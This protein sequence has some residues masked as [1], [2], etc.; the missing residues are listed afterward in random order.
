VSNRR[1]LELVLLGAASLPIMILFALIGIQAQ[2]EFN[3]TYLMVPTALFALFIALHLI[4]RFT[5]PGADAVLLP[6]TFVLTGTG[7][8]FIMRLVPDLAINQ[9]LWLVISVIAAALALFIVPSLEKVGRYKYLLMI[10]GLILLLL[11]AFI[12]TEINGSKLWI[13]IGGFSIQPGEIARIFII[14]FLASYLAENRE[15][16]SIS[17][18]KILGIPLPEVRTLGPLVLMWAISFL[19]LIYETDLGSSLLFFCIFLVMLYAATGRFSYVMVG[20]GLFA[21][22]AVIAYRLFYHVQTRVAIWLDPFADAM[23]SGYQLVQSLFAFAAG[24]LFGTGPG[25]GLPTRIPF[26]DTDFIFAAIGEELG[27][28]GASAILICFLVFIYRGLTTASRAKT[29]MAALTATGLTASIALQVFVIVGGVTSLIPLTGI[30]VPFISRGGSSMV[31]SFVL[32][33]LM[34]RA[35]DESRGETVALKTV[36][37]GHTILGRVALGKRLGALS[38]FFTILVTLL[39]GNL[40]WI[41]VASAETLKNNPYNTRSLAEER[42]VARGSILSAD[43]VVLAESAPVGDGTYTRIYPL[44]DVAAHTLGYYSHEYGRTGVESIANTTLTGKRSFHSWT[45]VVDSAMGKPVQGDNVVLTID[46]RIQLAAEEAMRGHTG[47]VVAIDPRTGAVLASVSTPAFNP[48]TIDEEMDQHK[49]SEGAPLLDRARSTLLAPGST[50]KVVT[51][52][53][54]LAEN[55]ATPDSIYPAPGVMDI[56]NAPVTNFDKTAYGDISLT[57]ATAYS[58]NTVFGQLAVEMGAERLV[59]QAKKFGFNN[60]IPYDLEIAASL[61]PNP[62][63]M[64][65]WET[66][67][68]GV[69]QP[70]GE[71][72]STHPS[73]AGPQATVFQ[74]ALVAA[75]IANGGEIMQPYVID[76]IQASDGT[77]SLLGRTS[78]KRWLTATDALTASRINDVMKATVAGGAGAA[79]QVP[80][81]TIAG[82]TGT[83]ELGPEKE[84]NAWFIVYAPADDPVIAIAVLIEHGGFGGYAAAPI[85]RPMLEAA[86]SR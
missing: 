43:N 53:A 42:R 57:Q 62:P 31:S 22:G 30:T 18:K 47:A 60:D 79:A 26:V 38:I 12:G 55:V 74:M 15:M 24:G 49:A 39:I 81:V 19:I 27:L 63:E 70:V 85:A 56:G 82:K 48:E 51:L 32:L 83:A 20:S 76:Y 75:G 40:T 33:A 58:V 80:G 28:L 41:Q 5:A 73:P 72:S 1:N 37:G 65:T 59:A 17:T 64:T 69:G 2:G 54:A 7:I 23:D 44:G 10:T 61:M 11:P 86:L 4:V 14:L 13:T 66:A 45:D 3:W 77:Q 8:G 6:L 34:L 68:A 71:K 36:G 78:P 35:G 25:A 67:W 52:T 46:S 84:P 21:I 9:I 16:L 50:F 29:D